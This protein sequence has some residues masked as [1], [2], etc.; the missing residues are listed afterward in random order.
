MNSIEVSESLGM[1][2]QAVRVNLWRMR[3]AAKSLGFDVGRAGYTAGM[4]QKHMKP[5][6]KRK[7]RA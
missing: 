5:K 4:K 1:T 3:D 6:H 2:P 7:C